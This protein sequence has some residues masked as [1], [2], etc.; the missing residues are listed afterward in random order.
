MST[1]ELENIKHPD[2]SGN[3]I[4]LASDGSMVIDGAARV[5]NSAATPVRVHI[6]NSGTNDYGSIY[7]DT[8]TAYK[9]LIINPNG[10]NIGIGTSTPV[11]KLSIKGTTASNEQSHITF[12]NTQG[13]K[14]FA[15]G[16]GKAGITNNGFSVVNITD[17]T[18][19]LSIS[20][21]GYVTTPTNPAFHSYGTGLGN[22]TTV[23]THGSW[24]QIHD[25]GNNFTP[26]SNA[27]FTAPVAG[28]YAFYAQA[29]F[30]NNSSTPFYWRFKVNGN[31]N[32]IFYSDVDSA[33]WTHI[34]AF[35]TIDLS[36]NDYV[37]IAY[38]GDPD[39][40]GDWAHFGGYLIG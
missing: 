14:V 40:G 17:N 30:N 9:N 4:A 34:M 20:N 32:G 36:A 27:T 18:A 15:V 5:D 22:Q 6:N 26:G 12:E 8:A 25:K 28:V 3:N 37:Q 7:A 31:Y 16:S 39:E 29:N 21:S 13:S 33:T 2:N 19:P 35:I 23:G 24:N 1:L 10:G 11:G 38:K